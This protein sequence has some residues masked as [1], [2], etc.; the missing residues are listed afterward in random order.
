MVSMDQPDIDPGPCRGISKELSDLLTG[1]LQAKIDTT[2][3]AV[4]NNVGSLSLDLEGVLVTRIAD[5]FT[6]YFSTTYG[7]E[8]PEVFNGVFHAYATDLN[9]DIL[10]DIVDDPSAPTPNADLDRIVAWV[11][12][13][14]FK[15]DRLYPPPD[16]P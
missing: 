3:F 1:Q 4:Q 9:A 13:T 5:E 15:I 10:H 14:V 7:C 11:L 2:R 16:S 12:C 8:D 6:V